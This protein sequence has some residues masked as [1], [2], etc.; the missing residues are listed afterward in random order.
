MGGAAL[1]IYDM[2]ANGANF[3]NGG[4]ASSMAFSIAFSIA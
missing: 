1:A 2:F 4:E 3:D